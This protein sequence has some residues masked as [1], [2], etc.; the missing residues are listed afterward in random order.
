[1]SGYA[2]ERDFSSNLQRRSHL[3][4]EPKEVKLPD[5]SG[6]ISPKNDKITLVT[7]LLLLLSLPASYLKTPQI[8]L[9]TQYEQSNTD[10]ISQFF[11]ITIFNAGLFPRVFHEGC[12][13][14]RALRCHLSNSVYSST[15]HISPSSCPSQTV[16]SYSLGNCVSVDSVRAHRCAGSL[17][18]WRAVEPEAIYRKL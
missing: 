15:M 17:G 12:S 3:K 16:T 14:P 8:Y 4:W 6:K 2:P 11:Q 5:T 13:S 1:M 18:I 9:V 10:S 7:E